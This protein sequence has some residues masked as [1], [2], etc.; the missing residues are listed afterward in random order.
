[1]VDFVALI[2]HVVTV[3]FGLTL[4]QIVDLA[5]ALSPPLATYLLAILR[6]LPLTT[7]G[8]TMIVLLLGPL[9]PSKVAVCWITLRIVVPL[10]VLFVFAVLEDEVNGRIEASRV[11]VDDLGG[12]ER[13]A[14]L[15]RVLVVDL[16]ESL[17]AAALDY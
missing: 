3:P 7:L 11:A 9:V 14:R 12:R 6:L 15:M 5:P 8:K 2:S 13:E 1:M 4:P 10:A 17:P 16:E